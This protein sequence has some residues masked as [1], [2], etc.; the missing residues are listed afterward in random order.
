MKTD[1]KKG[2]EQ[3]KNSTTT[4]NTNYLLFPTALF[5]LIKAASL[6]LFLA[7][8]LPEIFKKH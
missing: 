8:K 7:S 2:W 3:Y 6:I 4:Q 5:I 1:F